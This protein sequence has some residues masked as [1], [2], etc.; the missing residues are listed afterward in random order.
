MLPG[1]KVFDFRYRHPFF[2]PAI[3]VFS[4]LAVHLLI[5][6]FFYLLTEKELENKSPEYYVNAVKTRIREIETVKLSGA[7]PF[8][9]QPLLQCTELT[10]PVNT[11]AQQTVEDNNCFKLNFRFVETGAVKLNSFTKAEHENRQMVRYHKKADDACLVCHRNH[12]TKAVEYFFDIDAP[13]PGRFFSYIWFSPFFWGFQSLWFI[14]WGAYLYMKNRAKKLKKL[15]LVALAM[16]WP[17]VDEETAQWQGLFDDPSR[18]FVYLEHGRGFLRGYL[19]L[20][21]FQNW[22]K[23]LS[24]NPRSLQ[25]ARDH[26]LKASAV[27]LPESGNQPYSFEVLRLVHQMASKSLQEH[28]LVEESLLNEIDHGLPISSKKAIWKPGKKDKHE[29]HFRLIQLKEQ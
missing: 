27:V 24:Q 9:W 19:P 4:V 5:F 8:I 13:E 6:V 26:G 1:L 21:Q 28:L 22:V 7:E 2:W 10:D 3:A 11:D 12:E 23:L 15:N 17:A 25:D 14:F 20:G 16:L 29:I 18:Y